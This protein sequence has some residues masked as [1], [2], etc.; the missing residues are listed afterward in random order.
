MVNKFLYPNGGSETYMLKL[1]EYLA[2]KGH[3]VQYF[4]MEHPDRCVGNRVGVYTETMDFHNSSILSQISYPFKIIYSHEAARKIRILLDDFQP[5]VVHLNNFNYQLTPSIILMIEKWRKAEGRSCRIIYTAH[6]FSLVCPNHLMK[7]PLTK[8]N[9]ELCLGGHFINCI[10]GRC[11][12]GSLARSLLGATE[13]YYWKQKKVYRYLDALICC[14][15]FMKKRLDTNPLFCNK[16]LTL[17]NFVNKVSKKDKGS[18][19]YVLYFGRYSIE[20]GF[21]S[22]MEVCKQL[23]HI[24]FVL[25]GG[26]SLE[27]T[28]PNLP[29]IKNLGFQTQEK[30]EN[31]IV[32]SR[33]TLCPSECYDNCPLSVMESIS[34][35]TPVIGANTGG[36]PELIRDGETGELFT[37]GN[38]EELIDRI[39]R[40]WSDNERCQKYRTNCLNTE[41]ED[42][43]SYCKKLMKIYQPSDLI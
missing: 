31:L 17:R 16:T 8:E 35:G 9:C 23:P 34:L 25:A 28:I 14:S 20:K 13:A 3:Q 37:Q 12:H 2:S 30:L 15:D 22:L 42:I 24:P 40:L 27:S 32:N 5:D 7:N 26:G 36:I 11:I 41:F 38:K 21:D 39:K 43:E 29:N 18:G 19:G 1:G 33:F 4:G 10:K 6:D